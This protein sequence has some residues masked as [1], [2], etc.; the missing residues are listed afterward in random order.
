ISIATQT[1][2]CKNS[3]GNVDVLKTQNFTFVVSRTTAKLVS[4]LHVSHYHLTKFV[5]CAAVRM[6]SPFIA[7]NSVQGTSQIGDVV[8][9]HWVSDFESAEVHCYCFSLLCGRYRCTTLGPDI[10]FEVVTRRRHSFLRDICR[11]TQSSV[12]PIPDVLESESHVPADIHIAKTRSRVESTNSTLRPLPQL[13]TYFILPGTVALSPSF[14]PALH[15]ILTLPLVSS[16]FVILRAPLD[17]AALLRSPDELPVTQMHAPDPIV[18]EREAIE[19]ALIWSTQALERLQHK[20]KRGEVP[21]PLKRK[22]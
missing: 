13:P 12:S 7:L 9:D 14:S 5:W 20:R 2:E 3:T 6:L 21:V 1:S 17:I 22:K 15:R 18:S 16:I 19:R 10:P 8:N 11:C 4:I